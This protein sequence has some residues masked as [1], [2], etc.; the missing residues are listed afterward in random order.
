[1]N[2]RHVTKHTHTHTHTHLRTTPGVWYKKKVKPHRTTQGLWQEAEGRERRA[3]WRAEGKGTRQVT[4]MQP[5]GSNTY[6]T[7]TH[8][9]TTEPHQRS[10]TKRK[11]N[12]TGPHKAGGMRQ[13]AE[14]GGQSGG[15][16]AMAQAK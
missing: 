1:M 10:E 6:E 13:K 12:H 14:S 2:T 9:H 8:T 5:E 16:R 4:R 7:H 15:R 3:E 11:Q